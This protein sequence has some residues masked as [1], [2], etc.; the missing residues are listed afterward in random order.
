MN[1]EFSKK[2]SEVV[3][4]ALYGE[5]Q[6]I[7]AINLLIS[8][9]DNEG[10]GGMIQQI[11]DG[12]HTFKELYDFRMAYNAALFNEWANQRKYNVHKSWKHKDGNLCFG[13][14]WFIVVAELPG[15]Q[16]TNHYKAEYWELFKI[17]WYSKSLLLDYDGHTSQDV[18]SRLLHLIKDYQ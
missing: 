8:L 5:K 12:H 2:V 11:S 17:P 9:F 1:N 15:G 4:G 10:F 14:G 3:S 18:F 6:P 16:V 7:E 13:G